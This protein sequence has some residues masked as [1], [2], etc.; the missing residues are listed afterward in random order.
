MWPCMIYWLIRITIRKSELYGGMIYFALFSM[1]FYL[2]YVFV[3]SNVI[4]WK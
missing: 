2:I 1:S 4:E 3:F